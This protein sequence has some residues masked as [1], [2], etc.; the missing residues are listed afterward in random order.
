MAA[1]TG[2]MVWR[3]ALRS[4]KSSGPRKRPRRKE[5][6]GRSRASRE[7][8]PSVVAMVSAAWVS[9]RLRIGLA[10]AFMARL[11]STHRVATRGDRFGLRMGYLDQNGNGG[12]KLALETGAGR[13]SLIR[14]R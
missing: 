3:A 4:S 13:A 9:R 6:P 10:L 12:L 1:W 14:G 5:P 8:Q 7:C 11:P 2:G